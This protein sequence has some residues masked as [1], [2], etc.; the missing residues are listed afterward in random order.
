MT[1]FVV[2][3]RFTEQRHRAAALMDAHNAWLQRG[4]ADGAWLLAGSLPDKA[5]GALLAT[6]ATHEELQRRVDEDPFVAEGVVEPQIQAITA[7]R[8][9]PRLSFLV[10][11]GA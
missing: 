4:F 11:S 10:G 1:L 8:A 6:G 9:D 3:L 5:G 7:H 2:T